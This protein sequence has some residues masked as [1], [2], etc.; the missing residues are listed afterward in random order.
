MLMNVQLFPITHRTSHTSKCWCDD[1]SYWYLVTGSVYRR[2]TDI[3]IG[4]K[5]DWSPPVRLYIVFMSVF[6]LRLTHVSFFLYRKLLLHIWI[7][8]MVKYESRLWHADWKGRG[9][10]WR[11]VAYHQSL[12]WLFQAKKATS[13]WSFW[14]D[15]KEGVSGP[16]S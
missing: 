9:I 15:P 5:R 11:C 7:I 10:W 8:I 2:Q 3:W 16:F 12:W 14:W 4:H 13:Y 6:V 1:W